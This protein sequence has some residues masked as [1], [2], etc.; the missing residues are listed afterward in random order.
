MTT[1]AEPVYRSRGSS[2]ALRYAL[3]ELRSGLRGFYV[4]I[5]CIALG[6]MAIAGVGSVAASLSEGLTRE[7]RT[8]LGGDV[9]FS[10]IQREAKPDEVAFLR[11]RGEVSVAA[12]LRVMVRSG[13]GRLALVELKAVDGNYPM[14]GEL[15]LDPKMP[16]ADLL[17]ERDGA[18]GAAVDS[19]LLA[20]L[21]LKLGDRVTI[22]NAPYQI[23]SVVEAEPD[24]LAGNVGLGPRFLVSETSLRATG[25]LQPGSLVRWIYRVRL[26]DNAADDRAAT[27]LVDDA[28]ATLPQAGWEIRSRG[29]A[30]P[31][32]ERTIS[33]FTQ[34]LT[35]V[36][37]AALLVGGVG[38]A[39]AVK[40]H[41]DRRR[42]VIAA[43]KALGATGRDV[44]TIYLTQVIVLAGIGSVIGLAAGAA[45]PFV[46]VGLFGKLLPLPVIPALHPDE[47]A[48]SFIYGLLTALA[49][50]LW[51]LGR[52]HDVPVAALFREEVARE[53]HRP[54]WSY[55]ALMAVVI[56]LLIGV[57]IGLAYDKRVAAVFVVSSIVVFAVL[58][59]VAAG[60]MALARRLPR[61]RITML[62]L[63]IANIYRP[64]AL[65]PSVVMSLGLGLAVLVTITQ[66]DGNL[67]RQFLAALPDRAPSFFFIDIPTT[68][69]D[70][71][72][73]F[74]KQTAPDS[75][76]E[77]V[78]MLR[79]RIVAA[80]GV[81]AEELG[82]SQDSEWVLQSDRGLTYTGEV[83]KGSKIVEGEWWGKDYSGPPLVSMERKI[84]DGLKLKIGDEVVVNVLGRDIPA[85]IANLRNIDW[86]GLGI[87]FVLVFSPNAF[88]GAPLTHVATLTEAHPD[89]AGDARI[90]RQVA[91]AFPMVTSVRVREAL[92]TI[93]TVVTN[94]VLAIRGASAVTLISAILVLGGALA[95]GHRHR[96][97]DAV[98]LKTLGATRARLLGAYALEYLMIGFATAV[99]GVIAGSVAAWLIVTRLMTLSFI[100]QAGSAAGVVA[101]ALVVTVG[102]GLAGTLLALNQKPA[103]V[104]RNL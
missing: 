91:D 38:V 27:R 59:G 7:G 93:G 58:R 34:F 71:F 47:L 97:Y 2:L 52:V 44:F 43:F 32:L 45:L 29:N 102:L 88:K 51:P 14:L 1:I 6:V 36:G 28:R 65:T 63:A 67:R 78:P 13:D 74:L 101:A 68:E 31:Q 95:A 18:F 69:A 54:R 53:W 37:L 60:L 8:L 19:T 10:L 76:V 70:R 104:L 62:R 4:F 49:F 26:P 50:G 72:G 92:E 94:L 24:K 9:A 16:M 40:S 90:I 73:A 86:Q 82:A 11:T 89:A 55:L 41:I 20:R 77:D 87:N 30:S 17:A 98:I 81:K 21:D 85:K 5:A 57:A 25:L 33:R 84:A 83:P 22:G 39:N 15:T 56:A 80:R 35:L 3:R 79:G 64:G 61:S 12:A 46:I 42:D 100:W 75:T 48:L 23:R 96:V 103:S 99:F 66:I